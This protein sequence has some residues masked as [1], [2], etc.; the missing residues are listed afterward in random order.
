[1]ISYE[2]LFKTLFEK[3]MKIKD[4]YDVVGRDTATKFKKGDSM[5][6]DTIEKLCN[7]LQVDMSKIVIVKPDR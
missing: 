4:L 6:L 1:M 2:P 5:R 7:H 3:D